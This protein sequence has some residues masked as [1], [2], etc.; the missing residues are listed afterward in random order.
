MLV[1]SGVTRTLARVRI[2]AEKVLSFNEWRVFCILYFGDAGSSRYFS[3]WC[4]RARARVCVC[5]RARVRVCVRACV[6]ACVCVCVCVCVRERERQRE[7]ERDRERERECVR[8]CVRACFHVCVSACVLCSCATLY[9]CVR[10]YAL[11]VSV[12][13][14]L[15]LSQ[16]SILLYPPLPD[17]LRRLQCLFISARSFEE[18]DQFHGRITQGADAAYRDIGRV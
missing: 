17:E 5:V 18:P 9:M 8:S 6:C 1:Q 11:F 13:L 4:A 7:T 3:Q 16:N 14:S 10:V 2:V 15:S 12:T